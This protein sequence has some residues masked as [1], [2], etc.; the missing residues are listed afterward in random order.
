LRSP[1][2]RAAVNGSS[3]RT[4]AAPRARRD[5]GEAGGRAAAQ[6]AQ[7]NGFDLVI[8]VM[9]GDE[10][11]RAAAT[12]HVAQPGIARPTRF[13]FR[14]ARPESE[15]C[16]LERQCVLLRQRGDGLSD[17]RTVGLNTMIDVGDH[18]G[19]SELAR[20]VAQ[21]IEQGNGINA[22]RDRDK[23]F[24]GIPEEPMFANVRQ[25]A[26]RERVSS[27]HVS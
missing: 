9:R 4:R 25:H 16:A 2:A 11:L 7:Q 3:G 19:Q 1:A 26:R 27:A 13:R 15:F 14:G 21:Q 22:T 23:R 6:R 18:E 12:L 8:F 24:P 20:R 5:T 17:G 10:V